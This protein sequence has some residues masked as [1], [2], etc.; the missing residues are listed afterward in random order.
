MSL[1]NSQML[2]ER[3]Y[4]RPLTGLILVLI[5]SGYLSWGW[6]AFSVFQQ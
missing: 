1:Q 4:A 5:W 3:R 6:P 2:A